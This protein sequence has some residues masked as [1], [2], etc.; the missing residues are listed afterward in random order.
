MFIF[1]VKP[2]GTCRGWGSSRSVALLSAPPEAQCA[3]SGGPHPVAP[4]GVT[5]AGAF[6]L[7]D[8]GV[9]RRRGRR[10]RGPGTRSAAATLDACRALLADHL[11]YGDRWGNP[12]FARGGAPCVFKEYNISHHFATKH[13][14]Y[15]SKQSTQE[16]AAMAQRPGVSK[17]FVQRATY[18][19]KSEGLGHSRRHAPCPGAGVAAF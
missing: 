10:W 15:T 12:L 14:N 11:S 5:G 13:A 9:H 6:F 18:R 4:H 2:L 7:L 1:V 19:K 16:R 3:A 17:L 8:R